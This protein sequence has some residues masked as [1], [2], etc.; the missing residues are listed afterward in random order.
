MIFINRLSY[1]PSALL[2]CI[3]EGKLPT[4]GKIIRTIPRLNKNFLPKKSYFA[5][6]YAKSVVKKIAKNGFSTEVRILT[7]N[8]PATLT[9]IFSSKITKISLKLPQFAR[10]GSPNGL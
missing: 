9:S 2:T 6:T 8:I 5:S 10:S 7:E 3:A 4:I 1:T